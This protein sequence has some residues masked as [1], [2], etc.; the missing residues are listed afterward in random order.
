MQDNVIISILKSRVFKTLGCTDPV[1]VAYAA[2]LAKSLIKEGKILEVVLTVD[3]NIYKNAMRVVIPK[4]DLIGLDYACALG[5]TGGNH[6][7]QL[8]VLQDLD[9]KSIDEAT[10]LVNEKKIRVKVK[11]ELGL[12]VEVAIKTD[13]GSSCSRIEDTY[14]NVTHLESDNNIMELNN[15]DTITDEE[16]PAVHGLTIDRI[17]EF[18][19]KC[20]IEKLDFIEEG[21]K[22]NVKIAEEGMKRG[23][24]GYFGQS[25]YRA[26]PA[27]EH[28]HMITYIKMLTAAASDMRMSGVDMPVMAT[29]GSGN[30]GITGLIPVSL[31][32]KLKHKDIE[33]LIRAA[34]LSHLITIYIKERIGIVSQVCGCSV[35]AGAGASA[36]IAYLFGGGNEIIRNAVTNTVAGLA[37]MICDGA[38]RGC[39]LKLSISAGTAVESALIALEGAVIPVYDGVVGTNLEETIENLSYVFSVGMREVDDSIIDVMHRLDK[40]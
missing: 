10:R 40:D 38:K 8:Q 9:E 23:G 17:I 19:E 7:Y 36:G 4:T 1:V 3:K 29:A 12:F 35:A 2:S 22:M 30:Q 5:I 31:V 21:C 26:I 28:A 33:S 25:L 37:G 20:P 6:H 27:D 18:A 13:L 39:A 34:T 16:P 24:R 15:K 11:K 14:T 32:A